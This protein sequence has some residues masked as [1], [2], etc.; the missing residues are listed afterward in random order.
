MIGSLRGRVLA[1]QPGGELLV[2]V[3]GRTVT[4]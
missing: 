1:R 4:R 3:A 2:E